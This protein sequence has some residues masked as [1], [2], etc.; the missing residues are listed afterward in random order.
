MQKR[1]KEV[2]QDLRFQQSIRIGKTL[3]SVTRLNILMLL[4]TKGP[5]SSTA[6]TRIL[7]IKQPTLSRH[8]SWLRSTGIVQELKDGRSTVYSLVI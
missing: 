6:I 4:N 8:M 1:I 3:G 2:E 5:L 7:G